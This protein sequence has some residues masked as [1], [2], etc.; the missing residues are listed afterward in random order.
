[1]N[2]T[3]PPPIPRPPRGIVVEAIIRFDGALKLEAC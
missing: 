2:V 3:A 1:M